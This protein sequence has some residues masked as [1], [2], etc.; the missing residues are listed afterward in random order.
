MNRPNRYI[1]RDALSL[2]PEISFDQLKECYKD[3]DWMCDRLTKLETHL[4]IL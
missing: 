4:R 2:S 3:K 1:A